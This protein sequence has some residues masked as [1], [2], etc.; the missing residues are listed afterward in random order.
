[1]PPSGEDVHAYPEL[2]PPSAEDEVHGYAELV[3]HPQVVPI[4]TVI[5]VIMGTVTV[6]VFI[7]GYGIDPVV[8]LAS[9]AVSGTSSG[10]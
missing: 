8:L 5:L 7:P 3:V 6:R 1:V 2:V 9:K 10:L 4:L